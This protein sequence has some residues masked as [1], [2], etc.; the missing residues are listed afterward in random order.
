MQ[1]W[2]LLVTLVNSS[3]LL[4]KSSSSAAFFN[5]INIV[6]MRSFLLQSFHNPNFDKM[7]KNDVTSHPVNM[8]K[9]VSLWKVG[10]AIFE[11]WYWYRRNNFFHP[12]QNR[13]CYHLNKENVWVGKN[14]CN[15]VCVP[16]ITSTLWSF[17]KQPDMQSCLLFVSSHSTGYQSEI[18]CCHLLC[19]V[20]LHGL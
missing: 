15:C 4:M 7:R 19:D 16:S 3:F 2:E 6:L 13:T 5:L 14:H 10:S 1:D 9:S 11:G 12:K 8:Y 18:P 20:M 17:F